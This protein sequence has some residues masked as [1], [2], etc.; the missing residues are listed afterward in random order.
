MFLKPS[1]GL[2]DTVKTVAPAIA[3]MLG[4]P[5]AGVAIKALSELF[6]GKSDASEDEI[7][8]AMQTAS[9]D[10]LIKL[11]ELDKQFYQIDADDRANARERQIEMHDWTP[12]IIAFVFIVGYFV[13]QWYFMA[14]INNAFQEQLSARLQD[15]MMMII[16]YFF[17]APA[18][19]KL[20]NK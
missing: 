12:N 11:K 8:Q 16:G 18:W 5:V 13:L 15:I 20:K 14:N 17:G 9:P 6:L 19:H 2:K 7:Y 4:G 1:G 10:L 3:T